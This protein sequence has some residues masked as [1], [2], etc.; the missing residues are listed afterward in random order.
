MDY[1]N[2]PTQQNF[3]DYI[4]PYRIEGIVGQGGMGQVF[5]AVNKEGKAVALKCIVKGTSSDIEIQR[6]IREIKTTY[7][8]K[9]KNIV[10]LYDAGQ[11]NRFIYYTMPVLKGKSL[12]VWRKETEPSLRVIV[13]IMEKICRAIHFAHARN[14]VHRDLKPSNIFID[15]DGEPQIMDFGIAKILDTQREL[16]KTGTILGTISYMAPEQA[17]G[18]TK[19]IDARS[20]TYSL[21][22]ILYE[23]I[24]GRNPFEGESVDMLYQI[25]HETPVSTREINKSIPNDLDY[26]CLKAIA[27][28][29]ENRYSSTKRMAIDLGKVYSSRRG[30]LSQS[31]LMSQSIS[32][33]I[34]RNKSVIKNFLLVLCGAVCMLLFFIIW[35]IAQETP[36]EP[37]PEQ[38][39]VATELSAQKNDQHSHL[40]STAIFDLISS[41]RK[42]NAKQ[43]NINQ[44]KVLNAIK[45][46]FLEKRFNVESKK[47]LDR[48]F[49][50]P[51]ISIKF[52]RQVLDTIDFFWIQK[53]VN[54]FFFITEDIHATMALWSL[55]Q[56]RLLVL[57][58]KASYKVSLLSTRETSNND[59][60]Y[61]EL[62]DTLIVLAKQDAE[63]INKQN[64]PGDAT[65]RCGLYLFGIIRCKQFFNRNVQ[66]EAK[67]FFQILDSLYRKVNSSNNRLEDDFVTCLFYE[68]IIGFTLKKLLD[69]TSFVSYKE[70]IKKI[71]SLFTIEEK[72]EHLRKIAELCYLFSGYSDFAPRFISRLHFLYCEIYVPSILYTKDLHKNVTY[73]Y[74]FA[75]LLLKTP[76]YVYPY[77]RYITNVRQYQHIQ[78]IMPYVKDVCAQ[79]KKRLQ[80]IKEKTYKKCGLEKEALEIEKYIFLLD[81]YLVKIQSR[82]K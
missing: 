14:V 46:W 2:R 21:G 63:K 73:N 42:Q 58:E 65:R 33:K 36:K 71:K 10:E 75:S 39:S 44:Q 12:N 9:H 61:Q 40:L 34:A 70:R 19:E 17:T 41:A 5:R 56:H 76:E 60:A 43:I 25:V 82:K 47:Y 72:K 35:Q 26:V 64:V 27:K 1:S 37:S 62:L 45:Q 48:L 57:Q 38:D 51:S 7:R 49:S 52:R 11:T 68:K 20:D 8:L 6:F 79:S 32:H 77:H 78:R 16:S 67:Q 80:H 74:T 69:P 50:H 3:S 18:R 4:G 15:N 29:K 31:Q 22:V 24:T 59:Q 55:E 81:R 30:K 23:M 13:K 66:S 28:N 54:Q 53:N